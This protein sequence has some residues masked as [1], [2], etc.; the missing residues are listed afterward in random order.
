VSVGV[1]VIA[2]LLAGIQ[3]R[4]SLSVGSGPAKSRSGP[5]T[6]AAW[7][8]FAA[9]L[10]NVI[11]AFRAWPWYWALGCLIGLALVAALL[12]T[13]RSSAF[14]LAMRPLVA[15]ATSASAGLLWVAY[16]PAR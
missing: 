7:M 10:S 6:L 5:N 4:A 15:V 8:I 13:R 9:G 12:V 14:W 1:L 2:L 11:W 3:A 16:P